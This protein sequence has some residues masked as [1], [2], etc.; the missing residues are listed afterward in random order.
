MT[1]EPKKLAD[2][3]YE[4]QNCLKRFT[5]NASIRSTHE[6]KFCNDNCRKEFHRNGGMSLRKVKG[7]VERFA[8]NAIER[9]LEDFKAEL[10]NLLK[11]SAFQRVKKGRAA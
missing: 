3:R 8:T 7:H 4:C 5:R 6:P 11:P 2:G 10:Q 9:R 1:V